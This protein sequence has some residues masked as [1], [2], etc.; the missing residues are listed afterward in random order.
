MFL[1]AGY[2]D[3][4]YLD[5]A[6]LSAEEALVA[7]DMGVFV[8]RM[9][10]RAT[11]QIEAFP[12]EDGTVVESKKWWIQASDILTSNNATPPPDRVVDSIDGTPGGVVPFSEG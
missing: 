9:R 3:V 7:E 5:A 11:S 4:K 1:E 6:E 12:I 10:W 8:R 2:L